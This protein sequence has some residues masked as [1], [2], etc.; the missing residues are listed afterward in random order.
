MMKTLLKHVVWSLSFGLMMW[1]TMV[2]TPPVLAQDL[3]LSDGLRIEFEQR[4]F[5]EL[6]TDQ[7]QSLGRGPNIPPIGIKLINPIMETRGYN[8][9]SVQTIG[10]DKPL[11]IAQQYSINCSNEPLERTFTFSKTKEY[12]ETLTY[13]NVREAEKFG[14]TDSAVLNFAIDEVMKQADEQANFPIRKMVGIL[15]GQSDESDGPTET[16]T[17]T[18][19]ESTQWQD[20][21]TTTIG[22]GNI[23]RGRLLVTENTARVNFTHHLTLTGGFLPVFNEATQTTPREVCFYATPDY[24]GTHECV[25]GRQATLTKSFD[26]R[27]I[28]VKGENL[29]LYSYA[30]SGQHE[31]LFCSPGENWL[32]PPENSR[33]YELALASNYTDNDDSEQ[34]VPMYAGGDCRAPTELINGW[35]HAATYFNIPSQI[36]SIEFFDPSQPYACFYP[37]PKYGQ[38]DAEDRFT[39]W[40]AHIKF[41]C[42]NAGVEEV[43]P[44][45]LTKTFRS[46]VIA[47]G[48][49]VFVWTEDSDSPKRLP[50]RDDLR[51]E[52]GW[53]Y[54]PRL[55]GYGGVEGTEGLESSIIKLKVQYAAQG[56]KKL[57]EYFSDEDLQ[58][59]IKGLLD[60]VY[61]TNARAEAVSSPATWERCECDTYPSRGVCADLARIPAGV[62]VKVQGN[63]VVQYGNYRYRDQ[64]LIDFQEAESITAALTAIPRDGFQFTEWRNA[65]GKLLSGTYTPQ[66]GETITAVFESDQTVKDRLSKTVRVNVI[67]QNNPTSSGAFVSLKDFQCLKNGAWQ[68]ILPEE[69]SG[70]WEENPPSLGKSQEKGAYA[71]ATCDGEAVMVSLYTG[72]ARGLAQIFLNDKLVRTLDGYAEGTVV[73]YD[74]REKIVRLTIPENPGGYVVI[75]DFKYVNAAGTWETVD[76]NDHR[77]FLSPPDPEIWKTWTD[78][79]RYTDAPGA[80]AEFAFVGSAAAATLHSSSADNRGKAELTVNGQKKGVIDTYS[81]AHD[82]N[83]EFTLYVEGEKTVRIEN[84]GRRNDASGGYAIQVNSLTYTDHA[85]NDQTITCPDSAIVTDGSWSDACAASERGVAL[86][87]TGKV[88]KIDFQTAPDFGFAA[89]SVDGEFNQDVDLY[90]ATAGSKSINVAW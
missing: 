76:V 89:I 72:Q 15:A 90:S 42:Y 19:I 57:T 81:E 22:K 53:Y 11:I 54:A 84:A 70:N 32:Y 23:G 79:R 44:E 65:A 30:P 85:G 50:P 69:F 47:P 58:F 55:G 71:E 77:V 64:V 63:G 74:S 35:E 41:K 68:I 75:K 9:D 20:S 25:A 4:L 45:I 43:L 28:R 6:D 48:L 51:D 34:R 40:Y 31:I 62:T 16:E 67:G 82:G 3:Q 59:K 33:F 26:A 13:Q 7:T 12:S 5:K 18:E 14:L 8:I 36:K 24:T 2:A 21:M 46:A 66:P 1:G 29:F 27:S 39:P 60:A 88:T 17:T 86:E 38:Y 56:E 80:Y 37:R 78:E 52:D 83:R 73:T 10:T 87:F 61:Q 49:E